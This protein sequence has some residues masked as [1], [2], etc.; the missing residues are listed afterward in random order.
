MAPDERKRTQRERLL[1]GMVEA[2]NQRGYASA[3]VTAVIGEARVSRPTFYEYFSDRDDCLK[4]TI[5]V[6]QEQIATTVGET[7][8]QRPAPEALAAAVDALVE[9]AVVEPARAR[10]AM[11]ESMAG[12]AGAL[13][14]RDRGLTR[15]AAAIERVQRKSAN[16]ARLPDIDVRLALGTVYRM[17]VARLR[18]GETPTSRL[19]DELNRWLESYERPAAERRWQK[20]EPLAAGTRSARRAHGSARK[21]P[22][23]LPPGR[24]T[25]S[26]AQVSENH[27]LRILY[28]TALLAARKGY[29]ATSAV[30]IMEQASVG[31]RVFYRH[32]AN[33]HEAFAALHEHDFQQ[34]MN[35][36]AS[37][38]F[39]DAGWAQRSWDAA[40][41]LLRF[42]EENPLE[43]HVGFVE[44][45]AIGPSAV[46][47]VEDGHMAFTF[48]L[49]EGLTQA[50]PE[51]APSRVAME[52]VVA[53]VFEVVYVCV[54]GRAK[55]QLT[56]MLG[57]LAHLW[58]SPFLGVQAADR[59]IEQQLARERA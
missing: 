6:I 3:N 29:S 35:V 17:L 57:P 54:R 47:R 16:D 2:T 30:D 12:G 56:G 42:L 19:A 45:Y 7:L 23:A 51:T 48:F 14:M 53:A 9:F 5:A 46:Q 24:P 41:A 36:T 25:L 40:R 37:A 43:A 28:A 15:I 1:N 18:R 49:Q 34:V 21:A 22:P 4:A 38:F 11:G 33:K 31:G 20:L 59:F 26:K 13:A 27:R 50:T 32:F 58:L 52:A 44:A 8:K 55:P 39:I 10:F